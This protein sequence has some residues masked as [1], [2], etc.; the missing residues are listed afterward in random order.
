MLG[1]DDGPTRFPTVWWY[2]Y[3][4]VHEGQRHDNPAVT[5]SRYEYYQHPRRMS[6]WRE[7]EGTLSLVNCILVVSIEFSFLLLKIVFFLTFRLPAS[8]EGKERK[9]G[10]AY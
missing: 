3:V 10:H 8:S 7:E 4:R 6:F 9:D 5:E 2:N 1:L